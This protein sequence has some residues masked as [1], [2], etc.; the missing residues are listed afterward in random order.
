[1][2]NIYISYTFSGL[3]D[4]DLHTFIDPIIYTFR[5][6]NFCHN[7]HIILVTKLGFCKGMEIDLNC[8]YCKNSFVQNHHFNHSEINASKSICCQNCKMQQLLIVEKGIYV[9]TLKSLAIHVIEYNNLNDLLYKLKQY[10][11]TT[12]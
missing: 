10:I 8:A 11:L 9:S 7:C 4:E 12:N 2:T 3:Y 5:K 1:M 6:N